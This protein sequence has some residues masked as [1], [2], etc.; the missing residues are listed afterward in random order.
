MITDNELSRLSD[1]AQALRPEWPART[2]RAFLARSMRNRTYAD[3]ALAL[4]AVCADPESTSPAR[5]EQ[6]G[7]WWQA[8]KANTGRS[9]VPEVGPGRGVPACD[10]VGHEHE[11]AHNCRACRAEELAETEADVAPLRPA[12]PPAEITAVA[13]RHRRLTPKSDRRDFAQPEELRQ[14]DHSAG[15][16][17]ARCGGFFIDDADGHEAH[18]TVFGHEPSRPAPVAAEAAS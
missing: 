14:P 9:S 7:P 11:T 2:T 18:R 6:P 1:M 5:V 13:E 16:N 17:C 12:P 10:R 4:A 3:L 15:A 8:A